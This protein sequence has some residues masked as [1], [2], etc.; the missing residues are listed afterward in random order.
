MQLVSASP[1]ASRF[2]RRLLPFA[3]VLAVAATVAGCATATNDAALAEARAIDTTCAVGP[4]CDAKWEAAQ[5]WIVKNAGF[6]MQTVTNVVLQ[7]Y[8]PSGD[9]SD[10]TRIAVTA[11]R[12]PAGPQ[13]SRIFVTVRCGNPFGCTPE[14]Q[15][16][17]LDFKR[18]VHA[19]QP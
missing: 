7:T 5:L 3:A 15:Q 18:T 19:A 10:S 9:V 4:E 11:T 17:V 8:G 16:A 1:V 12:E 2:L 14:W 13:R 6:K